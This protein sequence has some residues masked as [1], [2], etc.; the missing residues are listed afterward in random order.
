MNGDVAHPEGLGGFPHREGEF[1]DMVSCG[2]VRGLI[3]RHRYSSCLPCLI[4]P[5]VIPWEDDEL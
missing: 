4:Y 1:G 5:Q 3:F 2:F